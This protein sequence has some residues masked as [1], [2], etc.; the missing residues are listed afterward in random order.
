MHGIFI[1][2]Y[3]KNCSILSTTRKYID[4]ENDTKRH[5]QLITLDIVLHLFTQTILKFIIT[6]HLSRY[7]NC[8][9]DQLSFYSYYS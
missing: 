1:Q 2:V 4:L 9:N 5:T 7:D 8:V 3:D 6:L